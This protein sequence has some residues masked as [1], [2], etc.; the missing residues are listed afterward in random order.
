MW[1][2]V[3]GVSTMVE[4]YKSIKKGDKNELG[5]CFFSTNLEEEY[6][7]LKCVESTLT[8]FKAGSYYYITQNNIGKVVGGYIL[9]RCEDSEQLLLSIKTDGGRNVVTRA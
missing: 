8:K 5:V 3:H 4:F 9:M 6:M 7:H 2:L 1:T